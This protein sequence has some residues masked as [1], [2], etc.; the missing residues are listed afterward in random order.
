M[1][2]ASLIQRFPIFLAT[3]LV[4]FPPGRHRVQIFS[5]SPI[6]P[7]DLGEPGEVECD[8]SPAPFMAVECSIPARMLADR[9]AVILDGVA[10]PVDARRLLA[11]AVEEMPGLLL[12]S[13]AGNGCEGCRDAAHEAFEGAGA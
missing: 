11:M 12:A 13:A 4:S 5:F 1:R 2:D 9:R 6:E 8:G 3:A 10:R 7:C